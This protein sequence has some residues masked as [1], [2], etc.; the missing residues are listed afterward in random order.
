MDRFSKVALTFLA[1]YTFIAVLYTVNLWSDFEQE[2]FNKFKHQILSN[3]LHRSP[4]SHNL[5]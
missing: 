2:E 3:E 5:P 1:A 4:T